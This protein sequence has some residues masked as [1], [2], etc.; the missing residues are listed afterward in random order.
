MMKFKHYKELIEKQ[1]E[2]FLLG[3]YENDGLTSYE[4]YDDSEMTLGLCL[5]HDEEF[6]TISDLKLRKYAERSNVS[7]YLLKKKMKSG[8]FRE[9]MMSIPDRLDKDELILSS[10]LQ[11]EKKVSAV[12]LR[13]INDIIIFNS[14]Y[15]LLDTNEMS[16]M[17]Y[18]CSDI[19]TKE[20]RDAT[21]YHNDG[22]YGHFKIVKTLKDT[23]KNDDEVVAYKD[24]ENNYY[25]KEVF[26]RY[27]Y[28]VKE[29]FT[30]IKRKSKYFKYY[31]LLK[32]LDI[33]DIID[34]I[35]DD[36]DMKGLVGAGKKF[37]INCERVD[38]SGIYYHLTLKMI[39][40]EVESY[41]KQ[42]VFSH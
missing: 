28:D 37:K 41:K 2:L 42:N 3:K 30:K 34:V 8:Y 12:P 33:E 22:E 1:N 39:I 9:I 5:D 11:E 7:Y 32:K 36:Y 4:V 20:L 38:D 31:S 10:L 24:N 18:Y 40:D 15:E 19:T 6:Y 27:E 14:N 17:F 35:C 21:Y 29:V 23:I 26:D 16:M 13:H 25:F